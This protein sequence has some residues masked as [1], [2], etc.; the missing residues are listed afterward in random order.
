MHVSTFTHCLVR[1]I[2]SF[3]KRKETSGSTLIARRAGIQHASS[4]TAIDNSAAPVKVNGSAGLTSKSKPAR[5]RINTS[6]TND[7]STTPT[8]ASFRPCPIINRNSIVRFAPSASRKP[9][10]R[11]RCLTEYEITP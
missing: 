10:S 5:K 6:A 8:K 7:P 9:S 3:H 2:P 1:G 4:D 11:V